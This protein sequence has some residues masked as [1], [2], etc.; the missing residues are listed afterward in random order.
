MQ[1]CAGHSKAW[2]SWG[3]FCF[4]IFSDPRSPLPSPR[5]DFA[6][7]SIVCTLR[8]ADCGSFSAKSLLGRVLWLVASEDDAQH[9]LA[10]TLSTCCRLLPEWMWLPYLP[11]LFDGLTR[12]EATQVCL[13]AIE[14]PSANVMFFITV[15]RAACENCRCISSGDSS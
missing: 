5:V 1:T 14:Q 11:Q 4:E 15:F 7:S 13:E 12:A 10:N 6:V 8:A 3:Q 9:T 2:L